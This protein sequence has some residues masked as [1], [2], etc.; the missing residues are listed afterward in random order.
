[1]LGVA[2]KKPPT[3]Q[4]LWMLLRV[5]LVERIDE[6]K[7]RRVDIVNEVALGVQESVAL[8]DTLEFKMLF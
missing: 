8:F 4:E 2:A 1:M 7:A 5:L 3:S 6:S